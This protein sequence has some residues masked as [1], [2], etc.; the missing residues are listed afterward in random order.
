M[1]VRRYANRTMRDAESGESVTLSEV[2]AAVRRG[3]PDSKDRK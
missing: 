3:E 2:A 1:E